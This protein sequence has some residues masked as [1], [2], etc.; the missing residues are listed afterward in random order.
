MKEIK[1][2]FI[3]FLSR[4]ELLLYLTL[5]IAC[6]SLFGWSTGNLS[7]A[8]Y[9]SKYIPIA[10]L[11]A[12][13]IITLT[14]IFLIDL[15]SEKSH[16]SRRFSVPVLLFVVIFCLLIFLNFFFRFA[17]DIEN[18]IVKDPKM[19]RNVLLGR[20]SP[21]SSL[22][23]IFICIGIFGLRQSK[24][25]IINYIGASLAILVVIISSV[26]LIGYLYQAPLLYGSKIIP[27]SLPSSV[28]FWLVSFTLLRVFDAN[29]WNFNR[30]NK[31]KVT[32]L[33]LRSFLPIVILVIIL[34]GYLDTDLSFN[35]I[36]P[37]LT[38]AIILLIVIGITVFIVYRVSAVL[39]KQLLRAEQALKESEEKFR[40]IMENSADAIFI[41]NQN[42]KYVYSNKA[43]SDLLG[44][45]TTEIESKTFADLSPKDK[46][47]EYFEIFKQILT[48]RSKVLTEI[49]LLKKDGTF[50]ST[51]LSAVL[52]P[53]GTVYGSCRDIT[54]R[55][56]AESALRESEK[57]LLR[58]NADKDIFISILG[59]DLKSPFS[60][61]LG[62]SG[63]LLE[64]INKLSID[65]I[66]D[67]LFQINKV[68]ENTYNLLENLLDWARTQS[69]KIPFNPRIFGLNYVCKSALEIF[70]PT[71][72]SKNIKIISS[73]AD[74]LEVFADPDMLKTVIRNL[75]SNAIKFTNKDGTIIVTAIKTQVGVRVSVADNGVG[76]KPGNLLKLFDISQVLSTVG[77][78]EE[79]GTGL[80]LLLC[81]EFVEK[82]G[83]KIWV[84]SEPGRGSTFYFIIPE[85]IGTGN[86]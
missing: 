43:A 23:F 82:N 5:I 3:Q 75:V 80:G 47:E 49:E 59:H 8:S 85:G 58:L 31:N 35:D 78:A 18:V 44:Y 11:N 77:T 16:F 60:T 13:I 79:T 65:E 9:S 86:F 33:L 46:I 20:M 74:E 34:Q 50:L 84:E 2:N 42:G 26:L 22:L 10:P 38:G 36:N 66:G 48:Q 6:V 21:I 62:L 63:A 68:A 71:A 69:G 7:L 76:I 37:P 29:F 19:F 51:D 32:R 40:S 53:D 30:L 67:H 70:D 83:G 41:T 72:A 24:T 12:A 39:G 27:V 57:Q 15:K 1:S 54:Q 56:K 64:D 73:I 45:S 25:L 61:L 55:K 52:L 14:L 81:K 4:K 28:C 17:G